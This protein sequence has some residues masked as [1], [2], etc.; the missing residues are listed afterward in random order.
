MHLTI[1]TRAINFQCSKQKKRQPLVNIFADYIDFYENGDL[2]TWILFAYEI[3]DRL[4]VHVPDTDKI[5]QQNNYFNEN[6]KY[7]GS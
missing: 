4:R 7:T 3:F 6:Y 5:N 2:S 1:N